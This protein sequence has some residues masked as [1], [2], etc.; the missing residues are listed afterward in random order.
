MAAYVPAELARKRSSGTLLAVDPG[1]RYPA[2]A[3]FR[4]GVL[5][6]ASRVPVPTAWAKLPRGERV[7]RIVYAIVEWTGETPDHLVAEFPQVY[8]AGK[9][10]GDPNDLLPL[11]AIAVGIGIRFGLVPDCVLPRD[12]IGQVPKHEKG[13]PW[14]SPRG[15]LIW[16]RLSACERGRVVASHDAIDATGIALF[17]TGRLARVLPGT[18]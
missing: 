12:W 13:D 14:R 9:S 2:A 3:F 11:A 8:R 10:P 1:L 5:T 18:T 17:A 6:K 15:G 4:D 16:S 7:F